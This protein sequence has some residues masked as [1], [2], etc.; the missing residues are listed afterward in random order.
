MTDEGMRAVIRNLTAIT[1]LDLAWCVL[2]SDEGLRAV[3]KNLTALTVLNIPGCM[4]VTS[5][6]LQA[7]SYCAQHPRPPQQRGVG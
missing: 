5:E 3:I 4:H 2:V 6:G 1:T 7:V